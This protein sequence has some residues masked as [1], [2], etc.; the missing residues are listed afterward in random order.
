LV[1]VL[2]V[3]PTSDEFVELVTLKPSEDVIEL[4]TFP[5]SIE[6]D[7]FEDVLE[8]TELETF[9]EVL[10]WMVLAAPAG[11][12]LWPAPYTHRPS[13]TAAARYLILIGVT[14]VA[15]AITGVLEC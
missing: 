3:P 7:T 13:A 14:P 9:D 2:L 4:E 1:T 6:L 12:R 10:D 15:S 5:E 8:L 11:W